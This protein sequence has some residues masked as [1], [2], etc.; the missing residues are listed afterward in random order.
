M[1]KKINSWLNILILTA[2]L[3][4]PGLVF[5]APSVSPINDK[6][7]VTNRLTEV[8]ETNGPFNPATE[9]SL[10]TTLGIVIKAALSLM[11]IIFLVITIMAGIKWMTAEGNDDEVKKAKASIQRAVIGLVVVISSWAIWAFISLNFINKV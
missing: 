5:A 2:V 9:T 6:G 1:V 4:L 11:G 8:A 10:A 3:I 7:S